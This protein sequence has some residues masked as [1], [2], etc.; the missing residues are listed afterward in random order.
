V[1]DQQPKFIADRCVAMPAGVQTELPAGIALDLLLIDVQQWLKQSATP[2]LAA[3]PKPFDL[4]FDSAL[5]VVRLN[6]EGFS[7][8]AAWWLA[9]EA[10][11]AECLD[12][13]AE[14]VDESSLADGAG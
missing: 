3:N 14:E 10:A 1:G 11:V 4:P 8:T 5:A 9:R 2:F 13:I 7:D 6:G 12:A